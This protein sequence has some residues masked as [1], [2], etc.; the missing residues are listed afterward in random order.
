MRYDRST[1]DSPH[2][3]YSFANWHLPRFKISSSMA[4]L[5][6]VIVSL[7]S[8]PGSHPMALLEPGGGGGVSGCTKM[9]WELFPIVKFYCLLQAHLANKLPQ[10]MTLQCLILQSS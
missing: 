6:C 8:A 2:N 1:N 10:A 7:T 9:A 5:K 3:E 4:A